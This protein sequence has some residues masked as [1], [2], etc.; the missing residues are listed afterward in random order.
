[1]FEFCE[2]KG[3]KCP[4]KVQVCPQNIKEKGKNCPQKKKVSRSELPT[5]SY[6]CLNEPC[7][8][9]NSVYFFQS[10]CFQEHHSMQVFII[11]DWCC[12]CLCEKAQYIQSIHL[13]C[14]YWPVGVNAE[15]NSG[16]R[17]SKAL[18]NKLESAVM[19]SIENTSPLDPQATKISISWLLH[20]WHWITNAHGNMHKDM[21]VSIFMSFG[22]RLNA[23]SQFS[24]SAPIKNK[25]PLDFSQWGQ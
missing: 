22:L 8:S 12:C 11:N 25:M 18:G 23:I 9:P 2:G 6:G 10:K 20:Y 24:K 15:S 7:Y 4:Q 17:P 5:R 1:M 16:K 21:P 13:S 3:Q 14:P 19:A